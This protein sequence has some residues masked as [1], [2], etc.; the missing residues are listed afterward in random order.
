[1]TL[2]FLWAGASAPAENVVLIVD[3]Q[4]NAAEVGGTLL[5]D[6][7]PFKLI[8]L[9]RAGLDRLPS[10]VRRHVRHQPGMNT[11]WVPN[12]SFDTQ[13]AMPEIPKDG[14]ALE[15]EGPSLQL[16][17]F[18]GP[19]RSQWLD[20]MKQAG[21]VL[22]HYLNSNG[23]LVWADPAGRAFLANTLAAGAHLQFTDAFHPFYKVGPSLVDSVY[24]GADRTG[25]VKVTI[26]IYNHPDAKTTRNWIEDRMLDRLSD[27]SPILKYENITAVVDMADVAKIAARPDVVYIGERFENEMDD[28]VQAQIIAGN[29]D[30]TQSGPEAPGYLSWLDTLG[31]SQNPADYPVV[32]V[33]DDGIGNGTVDSGDPTLHTMGDITMS[34][35]LAY[36]GN[37]TAQGNGEGVG[38]HGHINVSIA[39][40]FDTRA[41]APYRDEDGYNRGLGMNPYGLFAGTRIFGPSFDLSACGDTY[42]GV[43]AASYR[44]GARISTNSWGC[45]SCAGSYNDG[46]QAYDVGVRDADPEEAGNQELIIFFSA[47]NSGSSANTIGTPG[48][49]KNMITVGASENDRATWTDGCNIGPSG[50]DNAMEI[51][52]FSSRGPAPGNRTKPEVIAPGT[53]IQGTASTGANYDGSGVC[54]ANQPGD[55]TVFAASSGTSHS[56]PA[57]AGV[58]SL[59]HYWIREN[60]YV[61]PNGDTEVS[62]AL[63]KAYLIAHTTYLTSGSATLPDNN[64][65][66][67]MPNLTDS[68]DNTPRYLLDQTTVFDNTGDTFSLIGSV[69]DPGKPVKIAMAFTDQA[70]LVNAPNPVVNNLDLEVIVNGETYKGNVYSGALSVTGGDADVANNYEAVYLPIGT[71]GQVEIRVI[72]TNIAG[73][74]IPQV[75]DETDQ[76][77]AI[78]AYNVSQQP[79]FYLAPEAGALEVCSPTDAVYQ[80]EVGSVLGYTDAVELS[81]ADVPTG[82]MAALSQTQVDPGT[83]V[84]LTLSDIDQVEAGTHVFRII[85]TSTSGTK[86]RDL[87]V[88]V[89]NQAPATVAPTA[90]ADGVVDHT[91]D[92]EF[93]WAAVAQARDYQFELATEPTFAEPL[94]AQTLTVLSYT[95]SQRLQ[96]VTTYYW[97]VRARNICDNGAYSETRSF[98]TVDQADYY[99]QENP[100]EGALVGKTFTFSPGNN[101]SFYDMCVS[102]APGL[103]S[104]PIDGT[105]VTLSDDASQEIALDTPFTFYGVSYDQVFLGSNGFITFSEGD[106]DFS[107]SLAD[108]FRT[109]RISAIFDDLNPSSAGTVS[110]KV[111][112]D[113]IAITYQGVPEYS[114]TTVNTFQIRL[115]NNGNIDITYEA[116]AANDGIV[117]LSAGNGVPDDYE[118][119]DLLA[120]TNCCFIELRE[121][122]RQW[123][124]NWQIAPEEPQ[125]GEEMPNVLAGVLIINNAAQCN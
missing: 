87:T 118:V 8:R 36:V 90:P 108:H 91:R 48:N 123:A 122:L 25:P 40:G 46:S 45:S 75:G 61:S 47:G 72:G 70:G 11:L 76:D 27:W 43:I 22:V 78:V 32:D 26:Q 66:Y 83:T 60:L 9:P 51:I 33:T 65:G 34:T 49:G 80:I 10:D 63:M 106:S 14:L 19:V 89:A 102:D 17:Q 111:F 54:D 52:G 59:I 74:G 116:L 68:F 81:V 16:V 6:Y 120:G 41:D 86:E 37:C 77:F 4:V 117:G 79:D 1:M 105:V 73:D 112:D 28:E 24:R 55:Q 114:Q 50:A 92:P 94:V 21:I 84:T 96:P 88:T 97:R 2:C 93:T 20:E 67:G 57:V 23:Y 98:T 31:F 7:G 71:S 85:A 124:P 53:H 3:S 109:P 58:G 13:G 107:E 12:A 121:T 56:T 125:G 103:R 113:H 115:F 119:S 104:D 99:T 30:A 69:A 62:P 110:T 42:S 100:G 39:G 44:M 101:T 5:E 95:V 38:G 15:S 35:R 64:Q 18:Y 82:A 29:F